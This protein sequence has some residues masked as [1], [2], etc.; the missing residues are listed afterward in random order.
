MRR[1]PQ[2]RSSYS[3][4]YPNVLTS[5]LS[6]FLVRPPNPIAAPSQEHIQAGNPL[7][8]Q[9]ESVLPCAVS[10]VPVRAQPRELKTAC[11][12]ANLHPMTCWQ[13]CRNTECYETAEVRRTNGSRAKRF[14]DPRQ[15][16][17]N[18][19]DQLRVNGNTCARSDRRYSMHSHDP[20]LPRSPVEEH[21]H[22]SSAIS[23]GSKNPG[24]TTSPDSFQCLVISSKSM[25]EKE[26]SAIT[27]Y[28]SHCQ[29]E[30]R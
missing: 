10:C 16:R 25:L 26:T 20:E 8:R 14:S 23:N 9:R 22:L 11:P 30:E 13:D 6:E 3:P 17:V 29:S 28:A 15:I 7:P 5:F 19:I 1:P 21:D 18:V 12:D 24:M 27:S 4:A 2:A